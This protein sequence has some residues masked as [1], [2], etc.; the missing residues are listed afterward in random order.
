MKTITPLRSCM[1]FIA[2]SIML[3][4]EECCRGGE[5]SEDLL[6][7]AAAALRKGMKEEALALA[8]KA[9]QSDPKNPQV[10]VARGNLQA[11]LQR[12]KEAVADF[13]EAIRL[14]P[15]L[16]EA[17]DARGSA[18]F[19]LGKFQ[20]S[21]ADFDKA[22]ELR[23][24]DKPGHWR[25]GITC[26]YAGRFDEGRKQFEGYEQVDTNDVE[27]AVWH[28]L[29][30]ARLVGVKKARQAILKIGKDRRV[31]L[32]AIYALFR[33]EAKPDDVLNAA[34]AGK[35]AAED[36]NRRLFYAHLYLG[37]Y[38]ESL[39]EPKQALE[40]LILAV[41]HRIEH[42]M[43]DVARVHRDVLGAAK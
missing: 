14:D 20:Q 33:G 3:P 28:Y 32:M 8:G 38:F 36:L 6:R 13:S 22:L 24:E 37:L 30:N 19:K 31:P 2:A 5:S 29:C 4:P 18:H 9:V 39:G 1:L 7:Q 41:K 23:P 21:L 16:A 25:R 34:R 35:P 42:Y 12:Y 10:H 26:Y 11:A 40:H 15:K 43:W 27:N 17:H